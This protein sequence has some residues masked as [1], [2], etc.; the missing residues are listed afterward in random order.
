VRCWFGA[1]SPVLQAAHPVLP[2]LSSERACELCRRYP[3]A[4]NCLKA[5][6]PGTS[7]GRGG[8]QGPG[9]AA[10]LAVGP[11]EAADPAGPGSASKCVARNC[12]DRA[13]YGSVFFPKGG[14]GGGFKTKAGFITHP[15][16]TSR[17]TKSPFFRRLASRTATHPHPK[18]TGALPYFVRVA[19]LQLVRETTRHTELGGSDCQLTGADPTG[20]SKWHKRKR[21]KKGRRREAA[22]GS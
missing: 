20:E 19:M 18:K 9:T 1:A 7:R 2:H 22:G 6:Q 4:G 13:G 14:L 10:L 5:D 15:A 11:G 16:P 8:R 12:V 3:P 17:K 21:K